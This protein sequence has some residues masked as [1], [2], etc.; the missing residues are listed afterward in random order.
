MTTYLDLISSHILPGEKT[1]EANVVVIYD[2]NEIRKKAVNKSK[3]S[4]LFVVYK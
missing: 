4:Q 2:N 3:C 1:L